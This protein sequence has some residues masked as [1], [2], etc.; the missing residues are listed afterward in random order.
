M[1]GVHCR[2]NQARKIA[3]V[4]F[5]FPHAQ[6]TSLFVLVICLFMI[7]TLLYSYV[8]NVIFG[9]VLNFLTV[10]CFA[11]L[12][13]VARELE[14]PFQNVPNDLPLTTFQ[15]QFNESLLCMYSGFHPD[16]WWELPSDNIVVDDDGNMKEHKKESSVLSSQLMKEDEMPTNVDNIV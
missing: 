3:Y 15:A 7:P 11:G 1:N 14:N 6:I 16:S 12:H 4:P 13:E 5:P 2:Y 8:N 10:L 9:C